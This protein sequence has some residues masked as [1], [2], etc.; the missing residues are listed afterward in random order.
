MCGFIRLRLYLLKMKHTRFKIKPF[1]THIKAQNY[2]EQQEIIM[3]ENA[4][5]DP[6]A[7]KPKIEDVILKMHKLLQNQESKHRGPGLSYFEARDRHILVETDRLSE[8]K[9]I[10]DEI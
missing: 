1:T 6:F 8:G 2:D 10:S 4:N 3:N 9:Y 7:D 5:K